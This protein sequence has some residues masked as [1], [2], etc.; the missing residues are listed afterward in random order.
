LERRLL[1]GPAPL[2][3]LAEGMGR[4]ATAAFFFQALGAHP[5]PLQLAQVLTR[6]V[7][8]SAG[9]LRAAQARPWGPIVL[10]RA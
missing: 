1:A 10:A 5:S 8:C 2:Q 3:E 9:Q 6:A 7:L 4:R